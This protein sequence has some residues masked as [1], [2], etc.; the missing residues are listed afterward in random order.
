MPHRPP[1]YNVC[2]TDGSGRQTTRV[3]EECVAIYRQLIVLIAVFENVSL[4][5]RIESEGLRINDEADN[6]NHYL[7][8]K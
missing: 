5:F 6:P 2:I 1:Q 4:T 8:T 7:S 3:S